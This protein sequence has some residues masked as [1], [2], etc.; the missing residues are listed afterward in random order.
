MKV[1]KFLGFYY[2]SRIIIEKLLKLFSHL[3]TKSSERESL[4]IFIV[5]DEKA[6]CLAGGLGA[7]C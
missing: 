3:I 7:S 2:W 1:F 5:G 6:K 4:R